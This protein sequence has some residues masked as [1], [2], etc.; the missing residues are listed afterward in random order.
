[1]TFETIHID[2]PQPGLVQCRLNRPDK[3]NAMNAQMIRELIQA[4]EDIQRQADCRV[5]LLSA[6]GKAFSAGADLQWMQESVE[7][8]KQ[9]NFQDAWH[10]ATLLKTLYECPL[11]TIALVQGACYG[12]AN[13]LVAACDFAIAHSQAKFCFSEV[14]LGLVP[15]VISPYVINCIG[16]KQAR[17]YF[18]SAEVFSAQQAQAAQL[19]YQVNDDLN[20]AGLSL[21]EICLGHQPKAMS[22]CKKLLADLNTLPITDELMH[23]TA[24]LIA[25]IRA[26]EEAQRCLKQFLKAK[27]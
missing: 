20:T 18:L 2:S 10:L 3:R 7:Y 27:S 25:D 12:G 6:E 19:V 24:H 16:N 22:A 14:K 8:D 26:G 21:A 23:M 5:L 1:M 15:A 9:E 17:H 4:I 11:P 13:G